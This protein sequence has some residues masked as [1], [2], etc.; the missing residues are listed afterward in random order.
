[1]K[2][3]DFINITN[4]YRLGLDILSLKKGE[5]ALVQ[6]PA[7]D[8]PDPEDP[9]LRTFVSFALLYDQRLAIAAQPN[10]YSQLKAYIP[11]KDK[12]EE[13]YE[14]LDN[15]FSKLTLPNAKKQIVVRRNLLFI[16]AEDDKI[17]PAGP[18]VKLTREHRGDIDS[19][20]GGG[21]FTCADETL[22]SGLAY[23][24]FKK[25]NLA[26]ICYTLPSADPIFSKYADVISVLTHPDYRGQGLAAGVL[27]HTASAILEK[28]RIAA[29]G[30][31]DTN[32]PS[33]ATAKTA[34]F[35]LIAKTV[36]C[37]EGPV[38]NGTP[39]SFH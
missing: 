15:I 8:K 23:G 38:M 12:P 28:G 33:A 25:N 34:G 37:W 21:A 39:K 19:L 32:T 24:V 9:L 4:R 18:G 14:Y 27:S 2:S 29:Y 26:A 36:R 20:V 16:L 11:S 3:S 6:N 1:M 31:R 30:C 5:A 7:L 10:I 13:I 22:D 17:K 35:H